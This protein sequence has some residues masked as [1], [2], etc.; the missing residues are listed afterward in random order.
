M[1]TELADKYADKIYDK[2]GKID[3]LNCEEGD[4]N[5]SQLWKLT[6][7]LNPRYEEPPVA[8]KDEMRNISTS[9]EDILNITV[10]HNKKYSS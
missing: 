6:K 4:N 8:M 3:G 10:K 2:K 9:K 1:E 5:G 7:N